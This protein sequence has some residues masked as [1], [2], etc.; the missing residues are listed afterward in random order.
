MSRPRSHPEIRKQPPAAPR[1]GDRPAGAAP[2]IPA[3]PD[4]RGPGKK[5]P[6]VPWVLG[7]LFLAVLVPVFFSVNSE[8]LPPQTGGPPPE[9]AAVTDEHLLCVRFA[10]LRNAKDPAADALLGRVP[11]VP[12]GPV[13]SEEVSRLQADYFLREPVEI[14]RVGPERPS[15]GKP[16]SPTARFVLV[17]KGNVAAPTLQERTPTGVERSQRT[18]SNPDVVVEVRDCHIYGVGARLHEGP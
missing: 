9:P 3:V 6:L 15:R 13:S 2:G 7:G 12:D 16:A 5:W 4:L 8:P 18:L 1:E 10:N 14:L 17:T 11:A